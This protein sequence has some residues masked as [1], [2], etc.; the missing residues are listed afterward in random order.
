[1]NF[2]HLKLDLRNTKMYFS[3]LK[4]STAVEEIF[5]FSTYVKVAILQYK[6]T[7]LQVKVHKYY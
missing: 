3:N 5:R 2:K 7:P 4:R 1:M 6:Y